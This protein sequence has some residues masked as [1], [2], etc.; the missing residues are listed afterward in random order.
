[1]TITTTNGFTYSYN[2]I[3]NAI[4]EGCIPGEAIK[5]P[6]EDANPITHFPSIDS[7]TIGV[8]EQCN[9]RCSYCCYSGIYNKHREHSSARLREA[10]I[11]ACIEFIERTVANGDNPSI[12]FYGGE[13]LLEFGWVQSFVAKCSKRFPKAK[14]ELSTNGLILTPQIVDWLVEHLFNVFISIDG[15][16]QYHD[17]CRKDRNHS[18]T[19]QRIA[20]NIAHIK[21]SYPLFWKDNV[22][23][24]MT[25]P[26]IAKLPELSEA[27]MYHPILK[28]KIPFRMSEVATIYDVT[29]PLADLESELNLYLPLVAY[30]IANPENIIVETFFKTW[31]GEWI[32]RPIGRIEGKEAYPTCVPN[33]RKLFID[34]KEK[35]GICERISDEI[36]IGS[37]EDGINFSEVDRIVGT[38]S[39]FIDRRCS[40]CEIARVCDICPDVLSIPDEI[41]DV[42][43][44]NQKILQQVKFRCFCELAEAN[45]I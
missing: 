24:M 12:D 22:H 23:L 3:D 2:P 37:I 35:I 40:T 41:L 17:S 29:T 25:I 42:Y 13:S 5:I 28:D 26:D 10:N 1:M 27:W 15:P 19:F 44:H 7:F 16:D 33:N 43:C 32:E 31:L 36:R 14:Y 6:F 39:A 20:T 45:L 30:R 11:E 38:L 21:E 18:G 34:S 4:V 9:M 8:T